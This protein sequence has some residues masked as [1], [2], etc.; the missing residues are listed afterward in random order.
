MGKISVGRV[1]LAGLVTGLVINI[2]EF[3]LNGY[4]LKNEWDEAM[5]ALNRPPIGGSAIG[6]FVVLGFFLGIVTLWV[7]AA[8]RPRYGPGP[9]TAIWAGMIVWLLTYFYSAVGQLPIAIFPPRVVVIGAIW[10][11]FE[12]PIASVI[13]AWLYTEEG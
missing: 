8:I 7:Y 6:I 13:G 9:R 11:L 10:G 4:L 1:I 2:G 5:K 3:I 12:V